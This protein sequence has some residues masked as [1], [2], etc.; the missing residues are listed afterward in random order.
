M[1]A[2]SFGRSVPASDYMATM[3]NVQGQLGRGSLDDRPLFFFFFPL[4]CFFLWLFLFP[5]VRLS[6]VLSALLS[7]FCRSVFFN[8]FLCLFLTILSLSHDLCS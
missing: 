3:E 4:L 8:A 6:L 5:S 7:S 1:E 2:F